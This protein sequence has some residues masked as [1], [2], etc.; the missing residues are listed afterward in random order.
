[1]NGIAD[2]VKKIDDVIIDLNNIINTKTTLNKKKETVYFSQLVLDITAGITNIADNDD[3]NIKTDFS[4]AD[5]MTTVKNY[6]HSIFYNLISNSIKYRRQSVPLAIEI[7]SRKVK[8]KIELTF[9]DNGM[10]ID[11]NKKGDQVF[12]LYK[13]F[14]PELT[15][16]KGIGLFMVK[17][18]VEALGGKITVSSEVNAG[19]AFR[20][21][22]ESEN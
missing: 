10:G 17:T 12:G 11:L 13:R 20:I 21:E 5:G 8:D 9:K 3:L 1:M 6:I 22:F 16:G 7:N 2:S 15:E 19:T 18:Q 14:H 4:A